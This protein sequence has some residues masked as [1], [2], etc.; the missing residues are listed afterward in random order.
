MRTR[1][2]ERVSRSGILQNIN[3]SLTTLSIDW[4]VCFLCYRTF[5]STWISYFQFHGKCKLKRE[6]LTSFNENG[7]CVRHRMLSAASKP[8]LQAKQPKTGA[9]FLRPIP[10]KI[11]QCRLYPSGKKVAYVANMFILCSHEIVL[12]RSQCQNSA[13]FRLLCPYSQLS[14][15]WKHSMVCAQ[16]ALTH[17]LCNIRIRN[18]LFSVKSEDCV[19]GYWIFSNARKFQE[20]SFA[21][22]CNR[23]CSIIF[24]SMNGL[25]LP[26]M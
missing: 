1:T 22:S 10:I 7:S 14:C 24:K 18:E 19:H 4:F 3:T 11:E 20:K 8:K 13:C 17:F 26:W 9:I 23:H 16:I 6:H 2:R 21:F 12:L 5:I 25:H 15:S